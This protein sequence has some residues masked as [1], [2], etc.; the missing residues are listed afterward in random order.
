MKVIATIGPK[1]SNEEDIK[2]IIENGAEY[3]RINFSHCN[4][5]LSSRIIHYIKENYPSVKIIGDIQGSKIRVSK[6]LSTVFKVE[7]GEK[8]F[9]CPEECYGELR[10]IWAA[11]KDKLIPL[12]Y[13]SSMLEGIEL[14]KIYM[15]DGT[16]EF[17]VKNRTGNLIE[18]TVITGGVIRGEKG[19]NI[20]GAKRDESLISKK[21]REDILYCLV[22]KI[23]I[24]LYSFVGGR[25]DLIQVKNIISRQ[26][27]NM[28]KRHNPLL[29]AKIETERGMNH[30]KEIVEECDG[31]VIGRG[32]LVPETN[33][34]KI[35]FTQHNAIRVGKKYEKDTI[36]ATHLLD[37]LKDD[38]TPT[39]SEVN[40]IF[41]LIMAGATGFMLT[42]ETTVGKNPFLAIKILRNILRMYEKI[43]RRT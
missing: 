43:A 8:V 32:D 33:L 16:M 19:C 28:P 24:I 37:S 23:D 20:P 36:I 12:T 1:Y 3:I 31:I 41:Y 14:K 42:G 22:N 4:Y 40:N 29:W 6:E 34:Y 39:L 30:V 17:T 38:I 18:C 10:K 9:F 15:K 35:P 26:L 25:K 7:K 2:K 5:Q 13:H 27:V 21:D 11:R